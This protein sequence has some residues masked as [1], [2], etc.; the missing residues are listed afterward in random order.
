MGVLFLATRL[1]S[2]LRI[3]CLAHMLRVK[4]G[5]IVPA[6]PFVAYCSGDLRA[7]SVQMVKAGNVAARDFISCALVHFA[8]PALNELA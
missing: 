2:R 7:V 6:L 4:L 1:T 5:A 3:H 8:R